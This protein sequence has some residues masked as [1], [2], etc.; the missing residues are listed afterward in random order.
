MGY[1]DK[2]KGAVNM[3]TGGAAHVTIEIMQPALAPGQT[4]AIK[5]TATSTAATTGAELKSK[6]V[7]VDVKGEEHLEVIDAATKQKTVQ[8]SAAV[9]LTFQIAGEF[10]L[11]PNESKT[12]EGTIHL[13]N[14]A[15]PAIDGAV[16]KQLYYIRG[17]VEATGSDPDSGFQP[18]KVGSN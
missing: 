18:I 9:N 5:V 16:S 7:F 15:L 4:A 2:I 14:H 1:F 11:A 17:R 13:P 8:S 10:S 6:G 12:F 3:V